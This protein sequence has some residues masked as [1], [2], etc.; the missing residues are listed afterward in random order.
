MDIR[1]GEVSQK[2]AYGGQGEKYLSR[3]PPPI[4]Q[5]GSRNSAHTVTD[6]ALQ[7]VDCEGTFVT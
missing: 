4:I 1:E 5:H 6:T 3:I 2:M 7:I